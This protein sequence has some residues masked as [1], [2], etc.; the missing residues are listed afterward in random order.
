MVARVD[1]PHRR[2]DVLGEL[3]QIL[4]CGYLRL[5]GIPQDVPGSHVTGAGG[6]VD[7]LRRT[8]GKRLRPSQS[9]RRFHHL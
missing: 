1:V 5:R 6:R 3:A 7:N 9:P 4:A 8:R 2:D